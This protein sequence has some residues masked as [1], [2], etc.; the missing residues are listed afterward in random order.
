MGLLGTKFVPVRTQT[1]PTRNRVGLATNFAVEIDTTDGFL[2]TTNA[3]I[4]LARRKKIPAKVSNIGIARS[5]VRGEFF[6]C[7]ILGGRRLC[8]AFHVFSRVGRSS[9]SGGGVISRLPI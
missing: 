1:S 3:R 2:S 8:G 6:L 5:C 9:R 7:E 4:L